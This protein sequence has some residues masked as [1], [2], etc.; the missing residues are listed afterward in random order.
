MRFF[1]AFVMAALFTGAAFAQE[2]PVLVQQGNTPTFEVPADAR[3]ITSILT[4]DIERLFA[5][6][7]FGTRIV[8]E[9]VEAGEQLAVE[10][11]RI[12]EAL[13]E[14][15]LALA[16]ARAGMDVDV[17]RTEADAFD[18][19]A[20]AIRRA[21]D[22]KR[23]NLEQNLTLGRDQFF[24]RIQP[25]LRQIMLDREAFAVLDRRSVLMF[26]STIDITDQAIA[27]INA[28]IGDGS[29]LPTPDQSETQDN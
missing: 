27:Q 20:Q 8:R 1:A 5:Q 17:F 6:S 25:I 13:R 23:E 26:S 9:Y 28:S 18:E 14:E 2:A 12:A 22:A 15:E 21:Q 29:G 7:E 16:D 24:E 11:A 19:K 10:N 3:G 4:V